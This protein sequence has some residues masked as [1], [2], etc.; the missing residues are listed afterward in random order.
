MRLT[1]GVL[2]GMLLLAPA[3]ACADWQTT[4][5]TTARLKHA[6]LPPVLDGSLDERGWSDIPAMR[7]AG[8]DAM[9]DRFAFRMASHEDRLYLACEARVSLDDSVGAARERD[10][11]AALEE[12][13]F[14]IILDPGLTLSQGVRLIVT[15]RDCL[16]DAAL[17]EGGAD[18]STTATYDVEYAVRAA[19]GACVMELSIP[20]AQ[21]GMTGAELEYFGVNAGLRRADG[22]RTS[23]VQTDE[24]TDLFGLAVAAIGVE[25][26]TSELELAF[27]D[28]SVADG[29]IHTRVFAKNNLNERERFRVAAETRPVLG[30]HEDRSV[31]LD[32]G[33]ST[34]L[35][36]RP[37]RLGESE[38]AVILL[39]GYSDNYHRSERPVAF[40]A[41]A[42]RF[43]ER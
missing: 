43:V 5:L 11:P 18:E 37:V 9:G 30:P 22:S 4:P 2:C 41:L 17:R 20:W 33:R 10:D 26:S 23:L 7:P 32:D 15:V 8:G 6:P 24:P 31:Y 34:V 35:T 14:E 13:A 21:L 38:R 36:L 40:I 19:H 42:G 25:I 16:Y 12:D 28:V 3:I 1:L 29:A 39:T 27:D